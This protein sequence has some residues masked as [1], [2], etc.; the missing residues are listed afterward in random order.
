M[1]ERMTAEEWYIQFNK[2]LINVNIKH[3]LWDWQNERVEFLKLLR[4]V[5]WASETIDGVAICPECGAPREEGHR[6]GCRLG[7][8][9]L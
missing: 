7:T 3:I 4:S 1:G 5:E 8:A 6:N 2:G 9:L